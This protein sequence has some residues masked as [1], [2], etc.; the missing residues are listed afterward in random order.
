MKD[1]IKRILKRIKEFIINLLFVDEEDDILETELNE[2]QEQRLG[3]LNREYMEILYVIE[4]QI[5]IMHYGHYTNQIDEDSFIS[6]Q[7]ELADLLK[8]VKQKYI[9]DWNYICANA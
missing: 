7:S 6:K 2:E 9:Q 4:N 8:N 1:K 5:E 3:L